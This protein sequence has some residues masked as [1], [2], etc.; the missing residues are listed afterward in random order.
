MQALQIEPPIPYFIPDGQIG[1]ALIGCGGTGSHLAQSLARLA[2]HCRDTQRAEVGL[3]F[4]DGDHIE[5]K[6]VGRQL[7]CEAEIGQNKAQTLA[8]RFSAAFGLRIMAMPEMATGE[9]LHSFKVSQGTG[10]LVGAVDSAAGRRTLNQALTLLSSWQIWLDCGNHES[11]GQV[12]VGTTAEIARLR[13]ALNLGGVCTALPSPGLVAPDL[14]KDPP[15]RPRVDCAAA[16]EDNAQS[17]CVNQMM[18]AI[19]SEYLYDLVIRRRLTTFQTTVDLQSLS[20]RST[21]ITARTI[22][23]ATGLTIDE[24]TNTATKKKRSAA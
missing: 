4:V 3:C 11:S 12:L 6:N 22:A 16:M 9:V 15:P 10:I 7:F 18:A 5:A 23:T 1:I 8:A 13:G 19:A 20:M 14:L 24:L 2:A 17:L 21:P